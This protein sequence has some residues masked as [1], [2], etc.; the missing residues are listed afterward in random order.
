MSG[1]IRVNVPARDYQW[2]IEMG[3][4]NFSRSGG[5]A[6]ETVHSEVSKTQRFGK[7]GY[8]VT[9]TLKQYIN[10]GSSTLNWEAKIVGTGLWA[11]TQTRSGTG[12]RPNP[13]LSRVEIDDIIQTVK[14][15]TCNSWDLTATELRW[16]LDGVLEHTETTDVNLADIVGYDPRDNRLFWFASANPKIFGGPSVGPDFSVYPACGPSE[17]ARRRQADATITNVGYRS[18]PANTTAWEYDL[19][20]IVNREIPTAIPPIGCNCDCST[21]GSVPQVTIGDIT[22]QSWTVQASVHLN[23]QHI[24]EY[25]RT[26]SCPCLGSSCG[27]GTY[28]EYRNQRLWSEQKAQGYLHPRNGP[29]TRHSY[30]ECAICSCDPVDLPL[31]CSLGT[32]NNLTQDQEYTTSLINTSVFNGHQ[33]VYCYLVVVNCATPFCDDDP[34]CLN[35][36]NRMCFYQACRDITWDLEPSC[37]DGLPSYDVGRSQMH[38]RALVNPDSGKVTLGRSSN[39]P[40]SWIDNPT[41]STTAYW[42]RVLQA[43]TRKEAELFVLYRDKT[44]GDIKLAKSTDAGATI[45]AVVTVV[46]NKSQG[47]MCWTRDGRVLVYYR[48]AGTIKAK[49]YD[50]QLALVESFDTDL[51][52]VDDAAIRVQEIPSGLARSRVFI[53]HTV[54]GAIKVAWAENARTFT[55]TAWTVATSTQGDICFTRDGRLWAGYYDAGTLKFKVY[56]LQLVERRTITTNITNL[57]DASFDVMDS[58]IGEGKWR[59]G[60]LY[61]VPYAVEFKESVDG[62]T[63]S[64]AS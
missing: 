4:P 50:S 37:A 10:S 55:G 49:A 15:S 44:S 29:I 26:F 40:V 31:T 45:T 2:R 22:Q 8:E 1:V 5:A 42:A 24:P 36:V 52:G 59:L 47:D 27:T 30:A 62:E 17:T 18:A 48:D 63:F 61:P 46:A 33:W 43:R 58:V 16:Y 35:G 28:D 3:A 34:T 6:L 32:C 19:I 53:Q 13:W 7:A 56:D 60:V 12:A 51:T 64:V 54:G 39:K 9:V 25:L 38:W 23:D 14:G 11:F 20:D 41:L 57:I 21:D